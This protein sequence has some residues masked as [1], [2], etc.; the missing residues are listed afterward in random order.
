MSVKQEVSL[1]VV[2]V[3]FCFDGGVQS[4]QLYFLKTSYKAASY[5]RSL[6]FAW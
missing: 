6:N 4:E 5:E 3:S 2:V 1:F